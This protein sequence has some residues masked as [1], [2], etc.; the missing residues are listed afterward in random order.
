MSNKVKIRDVAAAAGVS[1]STVSRAL[2]KNPNVRLEVRERVQRVAQDLGYRPN[3]LVAALMEQIRSNREQSFQ[4]N[5]AYVNW[6]ASREDF[7]A[8]SVMR[9][10]YEGAVE[11]AEKLGYSLEQYFATA[12]QMQQS[13]LM[14]TLKAKGVTGAIV[15]VHAPQD[16]VTREALSRASRTEELPFDFSAMATVGLGGR[17]H[18]PSPHFAS[19]DQYEGGMIVAEKLDKMGYE[20]PVVALSSYLDVITQHRFSAGFESFWKNAGRAEFVPPILFREGDRD[21]F[22]KAVEKCRPDVVV[23]YTNEIYDWLGESGR[24]VPEDIGFATFDARKH[25]LRQV[26]GLDQRHEEVAA[27]AVKLLIKQIN[28]DEQGLPETTLGILVSGR[29]VD[30]K[31]LLDRSEKGNKE[32]QEKS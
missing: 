1:V 16:P 9:R 6:C 15:M 2:R 5:L 3:P 24:S 10:F 30:G 14:R 28:A 18:D 7:E 13:R 31:S 17:F 22:L 27:A 26:S 21:G 23:G 25:G 11:A 4:G 32:K 8:Q 19:N 29:W 12:D 20:R